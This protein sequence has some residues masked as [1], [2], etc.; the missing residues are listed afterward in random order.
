MIKY[1]I[2]RPVLPALDNY[3]HYIKTV[4][5]KVWLTNNG[6]M[7]QELER[8]L[9]AF[10]GVK[11]LM[12][13]SNGTLALQVAYRALN[14]GEY[15]ITTPFSFAAT[16][17]SLAWQ[18]HRCRFV[19]IDANSFNI[20]PSCI[21]DE[22]A[23][24]CD[25]IVATHVFGNPCDVEALDTLSQKHQLKVI[26]DAAHAFGCRYK[27]QSVLNWGDASTLSLH[28]TKIFHTVEGGAIIFKHEADFNRAKQLINFGF[29]SAQYPEFVGIN[30][31][32]NEINAAMG[33]A[34]LD[35]VE[36]FQ[37]HRIAC[38]NTYHQLLAT[39][40]EFQHW[41]NDSSVNGAYMPLLCQTQQELLQLM[42]ML[43]ELGVQ[44]RR[45]FY[46]SLSEVPCY[47]MQGETPIANGISQRVLC[48]PLYTDMTIK[49]VTDIC[50]LVKQ[51]LKSIR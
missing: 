9:A 21:D 41:A 11:H 6:P 46:P 33:L 28:A 5:D 39:E 18:N 29:D 2:V 1:P 47:G 48:L 34:L 50:E 15:V 25:G 3:Q 7:H 44:T 37:S 14:L 24:K 43:A 19:D 42:P 27:G 16:A 20:D 13:V 31:K 38:V 22:L 17:S 45:Y 49:D 12:L 40:F 10:L 26:Y 23:A 8:R 36:R 30:A 4:F 32:L 35:D 51:A